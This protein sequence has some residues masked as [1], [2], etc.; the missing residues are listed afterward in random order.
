MKHITPARIA[1]A[2]VV[3][4]SLSLL[5]SGLVSAGQE[6]WIDV[7]SAEEYEAGHL[8][9]AINIPYEEIGAEIAALELSKD[10]AIYLYCRSGRRAGVALETL[11]AEGYSNVRNVGGYEEAQAWKMNK[12]PVKKKA[13][14]KKAK[15]HKAGV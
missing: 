8:E 7:R 10:Q 9:Q 5:L 1:L 6:V 11:Q 12:S 3:F 15:A 13:G 14:V 4:L 2:R